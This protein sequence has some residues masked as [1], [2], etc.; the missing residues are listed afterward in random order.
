MYIYFEEIWSD[1]DLGS[2]FILHTVKPVANDHP[3]D[4]K[5]VGIVDCWSLFR[6]IF[7]IQTLK[8]GPKNSGRYVEVV[9]SS[10][11]TVYNFL[12]RFSFE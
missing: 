2:K 4:P 11:L 6:V 1:L 8:S 9:V 10:G 7:M 5:I 12:N 3:W